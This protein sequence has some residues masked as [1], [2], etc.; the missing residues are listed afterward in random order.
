MTYSISE[1][2]WTFVPDVL[3]SSITSFLLLTF[4]RFHADIFSNFPHFLS[5]AAFA[6]GIFMTWDMRINLCTK[7][8]CCSE[9][10]PFPAIWSSWWFGRD[11]PIRGLVDSLTFKIHASF[12]LIFLDL[13]PFPQFWLFLLILQGIAGATGVS[14]FFRAFLMV[15]LTS[16]SSGSMK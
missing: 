10:S 8:K 7:Q 6:A 4:V 16:L 5:T 1:T 13:S 15:S 3:A 12:D 14:N 2:K 9:L 11:S